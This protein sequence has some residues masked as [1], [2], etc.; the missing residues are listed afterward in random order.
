MPVTIH[1][2]GTS[3]SLVHKGSMG[4]V[5]STLPDVCKT[6]SPGG[7]VP[8]PY[9]VIVSM[10][11]QLVKGTTTVKADGGNMCAVKGSELSMCNGDEAGTAGGVKSSTFMKEATWLLYSFDVKLDGKNACRLSDKLQMNHGNSACLAGWGQKPVKPKW[12]KKA[13]SEHW[14]ECA[15]LHDKYKEHQAEAAKLSTKAEDL[16]VQLNRR[17]P[18]AMRAQKLAALSSVLSEQLEVTKRHLAVRRQYIRKG[19]DKWDW[20]NNGTTEDER[21]ADHEGAAAEVQNQIDNLT[22]SIARLG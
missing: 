12:L 15:A 2:N 18:A 8:V 3:N 20:F 11:S 9:P 4:I 22:D 17:Q 16:N 21:R 14:D 10:S 1:V 19:C 6:P 7:P 5:K 13:D